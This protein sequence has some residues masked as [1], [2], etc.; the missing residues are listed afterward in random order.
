M[1]T[2]SYHGVFY[3]LG[4]KLIRIKY[5]F[6]FLILKVEGNNSSYKLK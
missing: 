2:Q 3:D 1:H 6:T 5:L 4:Q